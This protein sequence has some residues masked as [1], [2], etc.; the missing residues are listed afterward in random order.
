M[1]ID[2][3]GIAPRASDWSAFGAKHRPAADNLLNLGFESPKSLVKD[4]ISTYFSRPFNISATN[5]LSL[6]SGSE[7]PVDQA[8]RLPYSGGWW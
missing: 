6:C 1:Q 5:A 8:R 3:N 7:I 2:A 4:S